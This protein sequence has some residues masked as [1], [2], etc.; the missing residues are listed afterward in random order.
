MFQ[1][2]V[3]SAYDKDMINVW[4]NVMGAEHDSNRV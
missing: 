1:V 2:H 4:Y 3:E